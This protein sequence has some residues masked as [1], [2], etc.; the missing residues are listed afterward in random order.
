MSKIPSPSSTTHGQLTKNHPF[1]PWQF[2]FALILRPNSTISISLY[3]PSPQITHTLSL[4]SS[5]C[6]CNQTHN[7]QTHG[8]SFKV[9]NLQTLQFKNK[10]A[11]SPCLSHDAATIISGPPLFAVEPSRLPPPLSHREPRNQSRAQPAPLLSSPPLS[12]SAHLT[13]SFAALLRRKTPC[14]ASS[15]SKHG[16]PSSIKPSPETHVSPPLPCQASFTTIQSSSSTGLTISSSQICT[17]KPEKKNERNRLGR[18]ERPSSRRRPAKT[19]TTRPPLL[20]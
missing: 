1:Q 6:T 20:P 13:A 5:Y 19:Q 3:T 10:T 17:G 4:N 18:R 7:P 14:R 12:S 16:V 11:A 9:T 15:L 8:M 2:S